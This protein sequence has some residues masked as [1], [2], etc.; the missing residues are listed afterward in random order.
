MGDEYGV[1]GLCDRDGG[2][3]QLREV[4]E[5]RRVGGRGRL[6]ADEG[7]DDGYVELRRRRKS[8]SASR[9]ECVERWRTYPSEDQQRGP[10][11]KESILPFGGGRSTLDHSCDD[12]R[13]QQPDLDQSQSPL[14]PGLP[15]ASRYSLFFPLGDCRGRSG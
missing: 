15:R 10:S 7:E 13:P 3:D 1:E 8:R 11:D 14:C 5:D 2:R 9:Y 4:E 12:D 6:T